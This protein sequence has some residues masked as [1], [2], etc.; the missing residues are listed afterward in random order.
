MLLRWFLGVV[1]IYAS[2][3][4]ILEPAQFAKVI[5]GYYL[6]PEFS[7]NLIAIV[8]PY[9]EFFTGIALILNIYSQGAVIIINFLL[10]SFIIIISINLIRGHEFDCGCYRFG[11]AGDK[12]SATYLLFRDIIYF[13]CGCIILKYGRSYGRFKQS[14]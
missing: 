14:V 11:E 12:S 2:Y 5:Y 10:T 3:H 8:L 13:I 7:I 9:I 6:F 1:F 4:K